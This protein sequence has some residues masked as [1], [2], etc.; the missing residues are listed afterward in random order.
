MEDEFMVETDELDQGADP[1]LD[2]SL[3]VVEV[4]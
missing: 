2:L 4:E 1:E 3:L